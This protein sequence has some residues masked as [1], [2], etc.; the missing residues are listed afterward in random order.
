MIKALKGKQIILRFLSRMLRDVSKNSLIVS[1]QLK[2]I[3]KTCTSLSLALDGSTDICDVA[4]LS[5]FIRGIDDNFSVFEELHSHESD[6]TFDKA[7][8]CLENL[9]I[10]SSKLVGVCTNGAP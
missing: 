6:Q 4:Q 5:T 2:Y 9:Q 7:K 8:S 1:Q 3:V 10:D